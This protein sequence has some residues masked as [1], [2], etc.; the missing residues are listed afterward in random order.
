MGFVG[1]QLLS[2]YAGELRPGNKTRFRFNLDAFCIVL[3]L[4]IIFIS[5]PELFKERTGVYFG[6]SY[7]LLFLVA[8]LKFRNFKCP[9]CNGLFRVY[10]S[11]HPY[12]QGE[13]IACFTLQCKQCGAWK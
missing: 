5:L 6:F 4:P 3:I 11:D 9:T 7:P 8:A 12:V 10:R 2:E 13:R 1:G